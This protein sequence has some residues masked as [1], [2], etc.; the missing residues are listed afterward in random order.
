MT[1]AR[2]ALRAARGTG[3]RPDERAGRR[4]PHPGH[5]GLDARGAGNGRPGGVRA[6][7]FA[8]SLIT[9]MTWKEGTYVR[10]MRVAPAIQLT[11]DG[12]EPAGWGLR[13]PGRVWAGLPDPAR[14]RVLCLLAAMIAAGVVIDDSASARAVRNDG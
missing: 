9:V 10:L 1:I 3:R 6:R 4:A 8:P 7:R 5:R 11:L 13:D 2:R 12:C 14:A